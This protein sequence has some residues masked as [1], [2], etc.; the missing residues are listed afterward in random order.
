MNKFFLF[1]LF[2][3][4]ISTM[5]SESLIKNNQ[6]QSSSCCKCFKCLCCFPKTIFKCICCIFSPIILIAAILYGIYY[7]IIE[8]NSI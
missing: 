6:S 1:S 2:N 8:G 7:F 3:F 5:E 4:N